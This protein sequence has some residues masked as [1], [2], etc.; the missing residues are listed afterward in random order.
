M[1]NASKALLIAGGV[2]IALMIIGALLLM[3]S[4]LSSYQETNVQGERSAQV[5][6]FN[7]RF[8]TYNHDNVRG[9]DLYSLLNSVINYNRTQS[10]EGTNWS[11]Q[12]QE[13]AYEPMTITFNIDISQ[14]TADG[15]NRLF[16]GSGNTTYTV[17]GNTNT[18]ESSIQPII[19]KLESAYGTTS[20]T[21]FTTNLT[22]IFPTNPSASQQNDAVAAF[23]R[24]CKKTSITTVRNSGSNGTTYTVEDITWDNLK[25]SADTSG[26]IRNN[27]YK[28]YEYVQFKRA[29][30]DCTNVTYNE[31]TGRITRNEL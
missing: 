8:S 23:K 19:S 29:R 31:N 7:N 9:S 12:G 1:E 16:T 22:K 5:V 6:E 15:T 24:A 10:I 26:S 21:N 11:D 17:S 18:F 28:Y 4:N 25:E 20:L 3:F 2:L 30:F 14:L 13:I 27:I